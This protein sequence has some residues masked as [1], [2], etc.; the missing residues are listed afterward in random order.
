LQARASS[1]V[2]LSPLVAVVLVVVNA[3]ALHW[4]QQHTSR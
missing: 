3:S 1:L 4:R 2:T